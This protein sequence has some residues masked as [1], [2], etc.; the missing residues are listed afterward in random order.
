VVP[1]RVPLQV[2]LRLA[3]SAAA[4]FFA[5][6]A[7]AAFLP[8]AR[9]EAQDRL[10]AGPPPWSALNREAPAPAKLVFPPRCVFEA[11]M[12][13][14]G[15]AIDPARPLPPLLFESATPLARFQDAVEAQWG[16]RP[17]V[18]SNAYSLKTGEIFLI[19]EASYYQ[20]LRRV[21]DDSLAHE[22]THYIQVVYEGA[23]LMN[24]PFGGYEQDAIDA[25][26]WF[27]AEVFPRGPSACAAP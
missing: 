17:E 13:R 8:H 20:R 12:R 7:G 1:L 4:L 23:D 25:Q 3:L 15:R 26:T 19:D 14:R 21:I 16:G 2:P 22:L 11:L 24:D 5:A 27:R 10:Q 6:A 9:R 18:F